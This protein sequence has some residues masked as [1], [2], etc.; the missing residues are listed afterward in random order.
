MLQRPLK[1]LAVI[2]I[3]SITPIAC[4]T[5][6]SEV[7]SEV[8]S[9]QET[10]GECQIACK[11]TDKK[12]PEPFFEAS[13]PES[14][15]KLDKIADLAKD[16]GKMIRCPTVLTWVPSITTSSGNSDVGLSSGN[17]LPYD[18]LVKRETGSWLKNRSEGAL[19]YPSGYLEVDDSGN[20]TKFDDV[21]YV[22]DAS[23]I[24]EDGQPWFLAET[25][26]GAAVDGDILT[27]PKKHGIQVKI[28]FWPFNNFE[29]REYKHITAA[30]HCHEHGL[31]LPTSRELL[32][33]C[34]AGTRKNAEGLYDKHRCKGAPSLAP[35]G[36]SDLVLYWSASI[37]KANT[38]A[39]A[40]E[41]DRGVIN[42][43]YRY[44]FGRARCVGPG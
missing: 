4:K 35:A 9:E 12:E 34:T 26:P 8:R 27:Y 43:M 29:D 20:R 11:R 13:M 17:K 39:W 41:Q 16:A 10:T 22:D 31:R 30:K 18:I 23:I 3:V 40:F 19:T 24:K 15:C 37:T 44:G 36:R 14:Q 33:F 1:L 32:D 21:F 42:S 7:N 5:Q 38:F 28:K 2:T 6:N 25:T